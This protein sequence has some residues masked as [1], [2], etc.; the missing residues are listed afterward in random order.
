MRVLVDTSIWS[1]A[2][3]GK[4]DIKITQ[5][6]TDLINEGRVAIIGPI[7]QELLSGIQSEKQFQLLKT[8]L[9]AFPD[10]PLRTEEYIAAAKNYNQCRKK[11]IQ[12]SHIDFLICAVAQNHKLAIYT[13]DKDFLHYSKV[14]SIHL[15]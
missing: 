15:Y 6:L 3:R 14:L 12:G 4:Q 5:N 7:R 8:K 13:A 11:G 9:D 1:L 10:I 2:L